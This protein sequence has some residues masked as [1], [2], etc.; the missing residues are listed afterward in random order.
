MKQGRLET[1]STYKNKIQKEIYKIIENKPEKLLSITSITY[2]KAI[3][4]DEL[5]RYII[6]SD[7]G[8]IMETANGWGYKTLE[9]AEKAA[10]YI[11]M[12][13]ERAMRRRMKVVMTSIWKW[14]I[15]IM[16][17]TKLIFIKREIACYTARF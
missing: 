8:Y 15:A 10:W 9:S 1:D 6:V 11:D 3:F 17:I 16:V 2:M 13:A 5:K 14:P 4:L 7:Y 12:R